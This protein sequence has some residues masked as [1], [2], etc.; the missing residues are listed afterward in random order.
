MKKLFTL[1]ISLLTISALTVAQVPKGMGKSDPEAKKILDDVSAKFKSYKTVK[2]NF[3]LKIE[4]SAGKQQGV[5]TGVLMMKGMKYKVNITGQ[6]IFCDSKTVWTYDKSANEVQITTLD[7]SAGNIT[8][9]KL[10]TNFYDNDF[11]YVTNDDVKKGNKV[12]QVVELTPIDK[13]KPFFKVQVEVDKANKTIMSTKVFEKNGNKYTYTI[14][15]MNTTAA[16]P[17]DAFVFDVKK[18]PG[19]EVVDLR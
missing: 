3:A 5:K 12:Y 2:A 11:L 9:Q 8:P 17:D 15:A 19:V 1:A 7:N 6:E 4:N 13:T 16:I 18:Y 14:S 10:F